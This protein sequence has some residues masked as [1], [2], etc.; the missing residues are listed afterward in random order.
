MDDLP[1]DPVFI[2]NR[3]LRTIEAN[4]ATKDPLVV[5]LAEMGEADPDYSELVQQISGKI[6][7]L[8]QGSR[9]LDCKPLLPFLSTAEVGDGKQ[10]VVHSNTEVL[11]P[12]EGCKELI[13]VLHSTHMATDT[14]LRA[15]KGKYFGLE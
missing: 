9:Y 15:S 13:E 5:H 3:S 7:N 11:V 1:S 4:V 12:M 10:I 6:K 8:G 14:M 2:S